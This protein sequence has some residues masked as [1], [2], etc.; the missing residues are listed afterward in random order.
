MHVGEAG[1][2]VQ[3]RTVDLLRTTWH[4][5]VFR[6]PDCENSPV[7]YDNRLVRYDAVAV[8]RHDGDTHER[9]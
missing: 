5:H 4:G 1:H 8:H 3:S 2:Q 6:V 7:V 9:S